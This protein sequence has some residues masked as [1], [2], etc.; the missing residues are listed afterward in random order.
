MV[1][2]Q[3]PNWRLTLEKTRGR[4]A[5]RWANQ[6]VCAHKGIEMIGVRGWHVQR[7]SCALAALLVFVLASKTLQVV[8]CR[9]M[10]LGIRPVRLGRH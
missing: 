1:A 2:R 3:W 7:Q 4:R 8:Y 5:T 9:Y 10:R 6:G